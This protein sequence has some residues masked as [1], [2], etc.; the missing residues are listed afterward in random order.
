MSY[1]FSVNKKNSPRER[2]LEHFGSLEYSGILCETIKLEILE[3]KNGLN[4]I[5]IDIIVSK[6]RRISNRL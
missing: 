6:N 3:K 4:S 5:S 2:S 1:Y